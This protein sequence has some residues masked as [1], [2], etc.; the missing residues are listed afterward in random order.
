MKKAVRIL[1][2][3]VVLVGLVGVCGTTTSCKSSNTMYVS[4]KKNSKKINRN[5]KVRGNN[6]RNSSTYHS[7]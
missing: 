3:L 7:Y 1:L 2:M 5:Y 4:K 6:Q